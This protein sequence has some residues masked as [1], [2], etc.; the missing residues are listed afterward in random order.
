M[1]RF[2]KKLFVAAV[3]TVVS[4]VSI[5]SSELHAGCHGR[6]G[7]YGYG[8]H[9][10]YRVS[11]YHRPA[12]GYPGPAYPQPIHAANPSL[13]LPQQQLV[14]VTPGAGG[15]APAGLNQPVRL[16]QSGMLNQGM[17]PNQSGL[18]LQQQGLMQPSQ[19][20]MTQQTPVVL[21][22]PAAGDGSSNVLNQTAPVV[23]QPAPA[24]PGNSAELSALQALGG[25][26]PPQTV[27][28]DTQTAPVQETT[29]QPAFVG[30]WTA[31]LS[32]GATVQLLMQAD[33]TFRWTATNKS[34]S[35]SEFQGSY[36]LE[37]GQLTLIRSSD[38]QKL[39]GSMTTNGS[40]AF[41]FQLADSKAP[42]LDFNRG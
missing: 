22:N 29:Q 34:G 39:S 15:P 12:Y 24:T 42:G 23:S 13:H 1:T 4:A 33:G 9:S 28:T 20:S 11:S 10:Q 38:S 17:V 31:R 3:A 32:N 25:F 8:G 35:T 18:Q 2:S 19:T 27:E 7:G 30:N 16:N 40:N 41:S 21:Q 14:Q 5:M 36:T 6:S 26:A 37:G